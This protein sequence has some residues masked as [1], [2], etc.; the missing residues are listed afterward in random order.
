MN[1][2]NSATLHLLISSSILSVS[3]HSMVK[4][5][6]AENF[7]PGYQYQYRINNPQVKENIRDYELNFGK[8][9]TQYG[10]TWT[11]AK[12]ARVGQFVNGDYYV[13]GPVTVVKI[14]PEPKD[15]RNGSCLDP[16]ATIEKAGFDDRILFSRY[17][18]ELFMTPPISLVPGN[19]LV[20]SISHE[21][22][23]RIK[24]FLWRIQ[25]GQRSPVRTVAVLTCLDKPVPA[26]AFRPAYG[27]GSK[28]IFLA[29]DL[30]RELLPK[31][32]GK[33]I[34]FR[35]HQGGSDGEFT[36]QDAT[37]WFQRP[38]MDLIMDEFGA[39]VENMPVYGREFTRAVG[40]ASLLLCMDFPDELKEPLLINFIQTGIDL[41]GLAGQGS[42][43]T[44]WNALGGHGNGRKWP[45]VFSGI[46]LGEKEMQQPHKT[47][48]YLRFSE[49]TQTMF[50]R[51]W[52]GASVVWAGHVGKDGHPRY[53]D[54]GAYEHLHP[55]DWKGNTGESYRRCCTSNAWVAQAL[56]A[57]VMH[58]EKYW[59][60]DAFFSYVDRWM[61]ED[62]TEFIRI[63]K[64]L[65]GSDYG[66]SWARQGATWDPF[67]KDMWKKYRNNLPPSPDGTTTPNAED[68]WKQ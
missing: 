46:L 9:I 6:V 64:E 61:T 25:T 47:Y 18:P 30:K 56:A 65:R 43:P 10:I 17:D 42:H 28:N 4:A 32:S 36:I 14:T 21:E 16:L 8:S 34:S 50:D 7:F 41:W 35:C 62:D 48:P 13:V 40:I 20:S 67:T 29:R 58:A 54:W 33:G 23:H 5:E 68:T 59:D 3:I 45:I 37:R 24:P 51:S 49:D 63:I 22:M 31:L 38:W 55:K 15:G 53:P 12:P 26:D 57:R 1:I 2:I 66:A 19:S 52:T 39:P 11:F 60:H 27:K 44:P